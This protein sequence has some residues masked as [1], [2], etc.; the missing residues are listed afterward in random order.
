MDILIEVNSGREEAK[1]GIFPEDVSDFY[2]KTKGYGSVRVRGLMTMA[3]KCQSREEYLHYF[4]IV[5]DLFDTLFK[6]DKNAI[7]S[8]GMSESY[9]YA[10]MAGANM[11]RVGSAVFGERK[12]I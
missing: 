10:I 1:G 5:K 11:V 4:G 12:Y 3:P 6:D 9:E 2:E 7:L 8:M